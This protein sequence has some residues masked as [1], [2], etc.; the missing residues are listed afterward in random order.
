[1]VV[2]D[3]CGFHARSDSDRPTLRIELWAYCR[4]SPF[5]PW[6]GLDLLSLRPLAIRRGEWLGRIMD[7][8]DARGWAKQQWRPA[9]TWRQ[10]TGR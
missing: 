5:L 7:W 10:T 9:G 2:A 3:T 1:L 8:L 4:R 6:T